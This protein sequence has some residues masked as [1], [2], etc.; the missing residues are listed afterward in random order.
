MTAKEGAAG[1]RGLEWSRSQSRHVGGP[2][3]DR[4]LLLA[5]R[6]KRREQP[7]L[8]ALT[9]NAPSQL[10]VL[11]HDGDALS[12]DGAQVG[13]FEKTNEVGLASFL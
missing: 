6:P 3:K 8:G 5:C 11:W 7:N 12:V 13:V 10:D 2:E 9:A 4:L 1:V